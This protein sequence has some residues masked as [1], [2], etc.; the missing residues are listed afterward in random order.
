MSSQNL[1]SQNNDTPMK[2]VED[3]GPDIKPLSPEELE[4]IRWRKQVAD[5]MGRATRSE[6]SAAT[7]H[8]KAAQKEAEAQRI[9]RGEGA[10]SAAETAR[11][12]GGVF[13]AA[14][15]VVTNALE[16]IARLPQ[17]VSLA[18][19]GAI[20]VALLWAVNGKSI[21]TGFSNLGSGI[22][23]LWDT[24]IVQ[25]A[26]RNANK[27][28]HSVN[29]ADLVSAV[30]VGKLVDATAGYSGIAVK[31]DEK[32][33]ETCHIYYETTVFSYVNANEIDFIVDEENKTITP[34]L[35]DQQ[36]DVDIPSSDSIDYFEEN[37]D[38]S[39][40]EALELCE[41]DAQAEAT[42]NQTLITCGQEN[43]KKTI[44]AL[45]SPVLNGTDYKIAW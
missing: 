30:S 9:E 24:Y 40:G 10:P 17:Y 35:P 43:L 22:A 7:D 4:A 29:K 34:S 8:L 18:I 21:V 23:G 2:I 3:E 25:P 15:K 11:T 13:G 6:D 39:L 19:V 26:E 38:I 31:T 16:A 14:A 28:P 44:E 37:P 45:I 36:L 12:I 41:S 32:G 20:V 42:G 33:K 27:T 5:E 1:P